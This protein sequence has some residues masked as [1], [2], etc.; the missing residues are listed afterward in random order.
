[1]PSPHCQRA[2]T[3][4]RPSAHLLPI[5][6]HSSGELFADDRRRQHIA[7]TVDGMQRQSPAAI[8]GERT[9]SSNLLLWAK[10]CA[11]PSCCCRQPAGHRVESS[12]PSKIQQ[13]PPL[14]ASASQ[15]CAPFGDFY[16]TITDNLLPIFQDYILYDANSS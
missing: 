12:A 3:T 10:E 2:F 14:F 1:M 7:A 6:F 16:R 9:A 5:D 4:S 13:N 11:A 8:F 15:Y